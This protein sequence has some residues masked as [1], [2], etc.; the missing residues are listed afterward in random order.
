LDAAARPWKPIPW[1]SL[2]TVLELIWRPHEVWRSLAIDSA[3]SWRPLRTVCLSCIWCS[4]I[5]PEQK[6][7]TAARLDV[8]CCLWTVMLMCTDGL[9]TLVTN[10]NK[11]LPLGS[12]GNQF[13]DPPPPPTQLKS[14]I[15]VVCASVCVCKRER[16]RARWIYHQ[17]RVTPSVDGV[18]ALIWGSDDIVRIF[19]EGIRAKARGGGISL[20]RY[21]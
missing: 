9:Y 18:S 14:Y 2:R 7:T 3:D 21:H 5:T 4:L 6:Q 19:N 15:N 16:N 8:C 11:V 1:S 20:F 12:S 10:N 17:W 13:T